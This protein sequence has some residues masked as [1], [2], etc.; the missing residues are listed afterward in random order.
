M[1]D[2]ESS[3]ELSINIF[4]FD[5]LISKANKVNNEIDKYLNMALEENESLLSFSKWGNY[6]P[7]K[8]KCKILKER[9]FD[10]EPAMDLINNIKLVE[11]N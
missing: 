9:Y 8:Y 6:L 7:I 3:L 1:K 10:F 2:H 4:D 11:N 5:K